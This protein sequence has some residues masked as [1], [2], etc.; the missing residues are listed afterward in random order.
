M[1]R[2]EQI[3]LQAVKDELFNRMLAGSHKNILRLIGCET[4]G[5]QVAIVSEYAEGGFLQNLLEKQGSFPVSEAV[6]IVTG[7]LEGLTHLHEKRIIHRDLKPDNVLFQRKIPCLSDFGIS[8]A[9]TIDSQSQTISGTLGYMALECFDGKRNEQT[10]IWAVGAILYQLLAG[11]IPFPQKTQEEKIYALAMKEPDELAGS[12]PQNV[13]NVVK[14]S[15]AKNPAERYLSAKEMISDLSVLTPDSASALKTPKAVSIFQDIS[16]PAFESV[17][18]KAAV[19]LNNSN[20]V[21]AIN[22]VDRKKDN[23]TYS[24]RRGPFKL[25][26]HFLKYKDDILETRFEQG[27]YGRFLIN[28]KRGMSKLEVTAF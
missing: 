28:N 22:A 10:D 11:T 16:P 23:K 18:T 1:P 24:P 25:D 6:E 15:L 27:D 17:V 13:R 3:D 12:I 26:E 21:K 5:T 19:G 7:I 2:R 9:L 14:K 4:F 20:S 8:R